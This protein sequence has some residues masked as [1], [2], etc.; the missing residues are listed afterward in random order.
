[1]QNGLIILIHNGVK[2]TPEALDKTLTKFKKD[3]YEFVTVSELIYWNDYEIDYTG[4]QIK[5]N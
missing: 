1:M 2:N 5:L 4:K 3:G